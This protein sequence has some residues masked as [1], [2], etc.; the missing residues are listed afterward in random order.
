LEGKTEGL[1]VCEQADQ[2][3]L[4]GHAVFDHLVTDQECLDA[5]LGNVRHRSYSTG[6]WRPVK[7]ICLFGRAW[8][9]CG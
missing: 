7:K 5:G 2:A 6:A 8:K 4:L 9:R 1:Q 3:F